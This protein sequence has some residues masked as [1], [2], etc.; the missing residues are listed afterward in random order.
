M[1]NTTST[2]VVIFLLRSCQFGCWS[3][4]QPPVPR[5]L[6]AEFR[7]LRPF[8][9]AERTESLHHRDVVGD[10]VD[11]LWADVH[12]RHAGHAERIANGQFETASLLFMLGSP[13]EWVWPKKAVPVVRVSSWVP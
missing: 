12:D 8:V 6:T 3:E 1:G 4:Q 2:I 13:C 10:V 9:V 5:Q 7:D 11:V